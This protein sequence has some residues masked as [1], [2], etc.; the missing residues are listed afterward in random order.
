MS[1][2]RRTPFDV[3]VAMWCDDHPR[4]M[5]SFGLAAVATT[6]AGSVVFLCWGALS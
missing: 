6:I 5:R 2:Y 4:F 3:R 1:Y